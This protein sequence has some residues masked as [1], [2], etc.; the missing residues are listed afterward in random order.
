MGRR[1]ATPSWTSS[2][3]SC[4][5]GSSCCRWPSPTA[6]LP[7]SKSERLSCTLCPSN[8]TTDSRARSARESEEEAVLASPPVPLD[9]SIEYRS[10]QTCACSSTGQD[11]ST[12]AAYGWQSLV[13]STLYCMLLRVCPRAASETPSGRRRSWTCPRTARCTCTPTAGTTAS[14][15]R[16]VR[17]LWRP[18]LHGA[19]PTFG[20]AGR[21][22]SRP[23]FASANCNV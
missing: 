3:R 4:S 12:H 17:K 9:L 23:V 7:R 20:S 14:A 13:P 15:S 16:R 8:V 22:P 11:A 6:S 18:A 10:R 19:F 21:R 5:A 2:R 1:S